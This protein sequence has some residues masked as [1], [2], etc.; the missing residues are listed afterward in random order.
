MLADNVCPSCAV[1]LTVGG[2]VFAGA[3]V[4]VAV[5][6]L[7]AVL[8]PTLLVAVTLTSTVKPTSAVTSW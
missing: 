6:G 7:G 2:A 1:P 8:L 3:A 4:T 5:T